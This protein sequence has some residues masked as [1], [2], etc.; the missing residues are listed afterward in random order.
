MLCEGNRCVTLTFGVHIPRMPS[1]P[2][3]RSK[4]DSLTPP[5]GRD[6]RANQETANPTR[7]RRQTEALATALEGDGES[8]SR[9]AHVGGGEVVD[10]G[11]AGLESGSDRVGATAVAGEDV[12]AQ[13]ER[14]VV[15]HLD[16]LSRSRRGAVL[17]KQIDLSA[18]GQS[19]AASNATAKSST[20]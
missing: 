1:I 17:R 16:G 7:Q 6:W 9:L 12:G 14:T 11:H 8:G 13:T 18:E 10:G 19:F 4:P 3:K 15:G 5:K 20:S 2:A